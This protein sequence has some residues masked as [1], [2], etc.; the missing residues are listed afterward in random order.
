M[1]FLRAWASA[2]WMA[3][4]SPLR[5]WATS[6]GIML[7]PGSLQAPDSW[8][9]CR[10]S[11]QERYLP[12]SILACTVAALTEEGDDLQDH[13][14]GCGPCPSGRKF[15]RRYRK[16]VREAALAQ[17]FLCQKA[18]TADFTKDLKCGLRGGDTRICRGS[19][20]LYWVARERRTVNQELGMLK[21]RT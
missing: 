12:L 8:V 21:W 20:R 14:R 10:R 19:G 17:R 6:P 15:G 11:Q 4:H 7:Q 16:L 3:V 5:M 2:G 18:F 9:Q 1:I 13:Q